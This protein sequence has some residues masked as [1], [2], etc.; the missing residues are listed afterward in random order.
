MFMYRMKNFDE[1]ALKLSIDSILVLSKGIIVDFFTDGTLNSLLVV[2]LEIIKA[3]FI[4]S[5]LLY[6]FGAP[7]DSLNQLRYVLHGKI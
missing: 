7:L 5:Y 3:I 2:K 1:I 6:K 4:I